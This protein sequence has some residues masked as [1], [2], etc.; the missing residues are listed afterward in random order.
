MRN[1][2]LYPITFDE[3]VE[4]VERAYKEECDK[5]RSP[6]YPVGGIHIA[7]LNEAAK[8]LKRLQFAAS[9]K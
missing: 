8:R 5:A 9:E 1:T 3:M 4:A 7:A 2:D 6:N